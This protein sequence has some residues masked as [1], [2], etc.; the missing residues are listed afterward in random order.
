MVLSLPGNQ[1]FS[2]NVITSGNLDVAGTT[3]Y[4]STNNVN[5]GDNILELNFVPTTGIL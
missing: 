3:T 4:T 5:I 2:N 1:T